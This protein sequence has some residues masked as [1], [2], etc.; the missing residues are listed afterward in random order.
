MVTA[1]GFF[2][3][4][5]SEFEK[6]AKKMAR[7]VLTGAEELEYFRAVFGSQGEKTDKSGKVTHSQSVRKALALSRGKNISVKPTTDAKLKRDRLKE[8]E[9]LMQEAVDTGNT[10][11][12]LSNVE[13]AIEE[14]AAGDR[15]LNAGHDLKSARADDDA[16]TV[17]GAFQTVTNIV[18]HNPIKDTGRDR[19]FDVALYGGQRDNKSKALDAARELIAA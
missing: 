4:E 1:L 16:I 13:T 17:W 5:F 14:P 2:E 12:D 8:I 11:I 10:T 7:K 9:R 19:R 3:K 6:L 15:V 18:D